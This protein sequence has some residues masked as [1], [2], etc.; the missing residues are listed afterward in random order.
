MLAMGFSY[1]S[2][3]M[4]K[5]SH[6]YFLYVECYFVVLIRKVIGF[7]QVLFFSVSIEMG[8]WVIFFP[9]SVNVLIFDFHVEPQ[10][11]SGDINLSHVTF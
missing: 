7:C 2:F 10:L 9:S 4:F 1:I 6:V 11:H 3:I 5:E 8:I